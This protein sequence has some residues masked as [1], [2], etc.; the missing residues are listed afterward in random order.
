MNKSVF[1][2]SLAPC[3]LDY[4]LVRK[5]E[6]LSECEI[7]RFEQRLAILLFIELKCMFLIDKFLKLY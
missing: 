6:S 4:V 2:I 7:Y 5:T 3:G 1:T